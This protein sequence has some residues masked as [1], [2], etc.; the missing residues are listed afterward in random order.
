MSKSRSAD[1][2]SCTWFYVAAHATRECRP[3][4]AARERRFMIF[5]GF[6]LVAEDRY[7]AS[8]TTIDGLF[9]FR[10]RAA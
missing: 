10:A 8:P 6:Y 9:S 2:S 3:E 5:K 7:T 1:I 4:Q